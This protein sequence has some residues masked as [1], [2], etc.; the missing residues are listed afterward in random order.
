M[1]RARVVLRTGVWSV[2][3]QAVTVATQF[4]LVPF[5]L[6]AWGSELY[7]DWLT[8]SAMVAYLVLAEAGMQ[9]YVVNRLTGKVVRGEWEELRRELASATAL[10][11]IAIGMAVCGLAVVSLGL[12]L[13]RWFADRPIGSAAPL[14]AAVLGAQVAASLG[15]GLCNGLYRIIGR[16]DLGQRSVFLMR[17]TTL[18]AVLATLIA[19]GSPISVAS[20]QLAT[21]VLATA[22]MVL[23]TSRREPRARLG[24]SG[25][26]LSLAR[27]FVA[28]SLLFLLITL[29]MAL[30]VQGTVLAVSTLL[31]AAAVVTL[32]TTRTVANAVRQ[33]VGLFMNAVWPEVTRIEAGGDLEK[34]ARAHRLSA[35]VA[36]ALAVPLVAALFFAGPTLYE[37]WT[38][39]RADGNVTL[40]RLLLLDALASAPWLASSTV[41]IAI[42]R[43]RGVAWLNLLA[44]V[45]IVSLSMA[46][47]PTFGVG[48]IGAVVLSV[49]AAVFGVAVPVWAQRATGDT[50]GSY[51]ATIYLPVGAVA[52]V[53]L[54]G[55]GLLAHAV[56]NGLP[57][58]VVVSC[59]SLSLSA[60]L[61][62]RL[63]FD[64]GERA[65]LLRPL[66][67]RRSKA[68]ADSAVLNPD[69]GAR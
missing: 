1:S 54:G 21:T 10:Y 48:A 50:F 55:T 13:E 61:F 18:A 28:P 42:N 14:V 4:V 40:L 44:G 47:I 53:T 5:Y 36:C 41:L 33:V 6:R 2:G 24:L 43:H 3:T 15:R 57:G 16:A 52:L 12:P 67:S 26:D 39:G 51:A 65:L 7:G 30:T 19:G 23:E 38:R 9:S 25:A 35:K 46:L 11:V 31:G 34:L 60:A 27:T 66:R 22:V 20:V 8:L 62:W 17:L 64:E 56:P 58:I 45:L 69:G 32:A 68:R 49:N 29:A 37:I 63:I 59:T